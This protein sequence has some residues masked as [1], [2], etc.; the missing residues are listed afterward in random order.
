VSEDKPKIRPE[1]LAAHE[2]E[3][4]W[5]P[6]VRGLNMLSQ[7]AL[8]RVMK[9]V[10]GYPYKKDKLVFKDG[11]EKEMYM[12]T[13]HLIKEVSILDLAMTRSMTEKIKEKQ[14]GENNEQ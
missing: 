13:K 4:Y 12:L 7:K 2:L 9:Q 3:T 10:I 5:P 14:E 1:D 11:T 6:F 8:A